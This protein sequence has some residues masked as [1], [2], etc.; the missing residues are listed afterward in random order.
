MNAIVS[1]CHF[2]E[3]HGPSVLFCTQAFRDLLGFNAIA[4][5]EASPLETTRSVEDEE[6]AKVAVY[7]KL[8]VLKFLSFQDNLIVFFINSKENGV[9]CSITLSLSL[10]F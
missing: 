7:V 3:L 10:V 9:L 5:I 8:T 6:Q 2:C 4:D 1:I